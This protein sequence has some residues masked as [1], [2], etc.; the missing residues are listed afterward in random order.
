MIAIFIIT[1]LLGY[2]LFGYSFISACLK[3][4]DADNLHVETLAC[5]AFP[6]FWPIFIAVGLILYAIDSITGKGPITIK[7]EMEGEY[8]SVLKNISLLEG[9]AAK[10]MGHPVKVHITANVPDNS[11]KVAVLNTDGSMSPQ[12]YDAGSTV[13]NNNGGPEIMN[14]AKGAPSDNAVP[15]QETR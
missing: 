7:R 5:L 10:I 8:E 15:L 14:F 11:M 2:V 3:R 9:K 12:A 1:Y 4:P 13:G 6:I